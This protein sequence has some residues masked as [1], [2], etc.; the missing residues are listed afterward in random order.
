MTFDSFLDK[1]DNTNIN[2]TIKHAHLLTDILAILLVHPNMFIL[3]SI[4]LAL[5]CP[6]LP[7][8]LGHVSTHRQRDVIAC[9]AKPVQERKDGK[10]RFA[11]RASLKISLKDGL[12]P[13]LE[14]V[15]EFT[16]G[17]RQFDT[18][19]FGFD[20]RESQ[21]GISVQQQIWK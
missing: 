14:S 18:D 2:T 7:I 4:S 8:R 21:N 13:F 6:F 11:N 12:G 16:L 15:V 3:D 19:D 17:R 20:G 9:H 1:I 5:Q 10:P